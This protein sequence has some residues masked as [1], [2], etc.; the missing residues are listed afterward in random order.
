[1]FRICPN[2]TFWP[3][4]FRSRPCRRL[5][6]DPPSRGVKG[7]F[8]AIRPFLEGTPL[9]ERSSRSPTAWPAPE[10]TRPDGQIQSNAP[11]HG[12][13]S[14]KIA[15]QRPRKP[16]NPHKT[17]VQE[18]ESP[19]SKTRIPMAGSVFLKCPFNGKAGPLILDSR[20][21]DSGAPRSIFTEKPRK[22][23]FRPSCLSALQTQRAPNDTGVNAGKR[24]E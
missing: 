19:A 24:R 11:C 1:M 17:K 15:T 7:R 22:P 8:R 16:R 21:D 20:H 5:D 2:A 9:D 10:I 14:E 23:A 18:P 3:G 12:G 13:K 6:R 4:Y